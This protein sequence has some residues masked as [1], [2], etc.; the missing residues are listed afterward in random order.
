[1]VKKVCNM[2]VAS[3]MVPIGNISKLAA[4]NPISAIYHRYVKPKL[5]QKNYS[6]SD[7]HEKGTIFEKF[8][9]NSLFSSNSDKN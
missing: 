6:P 8:S 5:N 9:E 7:V 4:L 1:M 2:V 3:H